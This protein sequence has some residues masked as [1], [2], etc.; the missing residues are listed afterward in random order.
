MRKLGNFVLVGIPGV[1][2]GRLELLIV[3]FSSSELFLG[4]FEVTFGL[5]SSEAR[6]GPTNGIPMVKRTDRGGSPALWTLMASSF[7]DKTT[8]WVVGVRSKS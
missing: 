8:A 7:A 3:C 6:A 5:L 4:A 1:H 2:A